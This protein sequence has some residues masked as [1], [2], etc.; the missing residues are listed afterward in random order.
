MYQY[1][2][3]GN[4]NLP[5]PE[6]SWCNQSSFDVMIATGFNTNGVFAPKGRYD[7]TANQ[8]ATNLENLANDSKNSGIYEVSPD[9]AQGLA[10]LGV[11]VVGAWSG[12][13]Q[14]GHLATVVPES[15]TTLRYSEADGPVL[16]NVGASIGVM[17]TKDGFKRADKAGGWKNNVKFY[18]DSNQFV[19]FDTANV[20]KEF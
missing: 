4:Y 8:A 15:S 14:K 7:T 19:R 10:N 1:G 18:V 11:T 12:G 13:S 6:K 3:G 5:G 2:A 20:L 9:V 17:S 16:S